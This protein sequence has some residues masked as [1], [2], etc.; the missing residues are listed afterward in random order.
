MHVNVVSYL[1]FV[2]LV[3][4]TSPNVLRLLSPRQ[5]PTPPPPPVQHLLLHPLSALHKYWLKF[6][7]GRL[8]F[9]KEGLKTEGKRDFIQGTMWKWQLR[10]T[11]TP[12]N[13]IKR[14]TPAII[15]PSLDEYLAMAT[16]VSPF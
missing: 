16:C 3:C 11:A 5:A 14:K 12:K 13:E 2:K 4:T 9:P 15:K 1:F 7:F 8:Q 10:E 6:V